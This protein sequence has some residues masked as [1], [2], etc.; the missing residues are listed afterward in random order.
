MHL[1]CPGL[2]SW[3]ENG[4]TI[5]TST[6]VSAQIA[7]QQLTSQRL[8]ENLRS[9]ER[10]PIYHLDAWLTACWQEAR[11]KM[12]DAP[13]LLSQAQEEALWRQII[14]EEHAYLFD[15]AGAARLSMRAAR[16]LRDWHIPTDGDA[17]ADYEDA[18]QFQNWY[19]R[20]QRKC[21]EK[22]WIARAD[23]P[24]LLAKWIS[25][26]ILDRELTAFVGFATIPPA[27]EN[28]QHALG[29]F[30]A[31]EAFNSTRPSHASAVQCDD[32][33]AELECAARWA[34]ATFERNPASSVGIFVPD[35]RSNRAL[36]ERIFDR[37]LYSAS[38]LR[39]AP[40]SDSRGSVFH[41][42]TAAQLKEHPLI[43]SALLL[44]EL[45]RPRIAIAD[46]GAILR[47]PFIR[48]GI[49][50]RNARALADLELRKNRDLDASLRD[51][52][53]A[54]RECA[55]LHPFFRRVSGL[56][57]EKSDALELSAWSELFAALLHAAGWPGDA[58][59]NAAE[60]E[61][62]GLWNNALS[63]L[64]SLGLVFQSVP[65]T[66]A[67]FSLRRLLLRPGVQRGDWASPIQILDS[68]E[69]TGL[70]FDSACL[71]GLGEETWP[72]RMELNSLLPF[73]LQRLAQI[74]GSSP[75]S[76]HSQRELSMQA[77]F[78]AAPALAAT[79][80]GRVSPMAAQYLDRGPAFSQWRGASPRCSY[81]PEQLLELDDTKA[82][83]YA[84]EESARGGTSVIKNQSLCPFRAFAEIRLSAQSLED[85]CF[86]FDARDRGGFLH[87]ALQLVWKELKSQQQLRS[88][89]EEQ[90]RAV[91][92][93]AVK[94]AIR[95]DQSSPF[96]Q[97][98]TVTERER[99]QELILDWLWIERNRKTP[100]TVEMV[101]E[102]LAYELGGLPLQLRIDRI[103][104]LSNGSV[105]LIDYKSG[106]QV[107][108]SL[109]SPRAKEPQ[110][111]VYAA[112]CGERVDGIFF[113][114]LKARDLRAV[115]FSRTAHF[116][117]QTAK[118][119][120]D[121]DEFLDTSRADVEQIAREFVEGNAAVDP[122]RGACEYCRLASLCRVNEQARA[123]EESE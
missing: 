25:R 117:D 9:W 82:P 16:L 120:R 24:R 94:E 57:R 96:H 47:C 42:N 35:L 58:E 85:A 43:A 73:K 103:D 2:V 8:Q 76:V 113:A 28:V 71:T 20:F 115:G 67:L 54:S 69:A 34:R 79:F 26:G 80:S 63:D 100:F 84:P 123:A 31:T 81:A 97:L 61:I 55:L 65:F 51:L 52:E 1:A 48:G 74:P 10:R 111:L 17:W 50:E 101:E 121:W 23:V 88:T 36:I 3:F 114:Q 64:A 105:V 106:K 110:L 30:S 118:V 45:L 89:G 15:A 78:A 109:Q 108:T 91:I 29:L 95:D 98:I 104:R 60:L 119:R 27:I 41:V 7:D 116:S 83:R 21:R 22:N 18:H 37:I 4:A 93:K 75:Q 14:E 32:F 86:G 19:S 102:K 38:A 112:S 59:L 107:S 77:L 12:S 68:S 92:E 46:A 6:R 5:V 70:R 90:L 49:A 40:S 66:A 72:S 87:K 53:F 56:L 11:Y 33:S 122:L 13:L 39:F 99:L 62:T 44:L